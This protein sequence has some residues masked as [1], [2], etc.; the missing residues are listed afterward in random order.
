MKMFLVYQDFDSMQP[1]QDIMNYW[2]SIK[3]LLCNK[4]DV[5]I[6]NT[7]NR[8]L[9]SLY[10]MQIELLFIVY[11]TSFQTLKSTLW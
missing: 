10:C 5:H 11:L 1:H 7:C 6:E 4:Y 3:Q 2:I 9:F 8:S